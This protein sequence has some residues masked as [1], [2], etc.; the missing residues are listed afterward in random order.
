MTTQLSSSQDSGSVCDITCFSQDLFTVR[1]REPPGL[2]LVL[3]YTSELICW[4]PPIFQARP[5][6]LVSLDEEPV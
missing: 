6:R 3:A 5:H 1:K 4:V 2:F